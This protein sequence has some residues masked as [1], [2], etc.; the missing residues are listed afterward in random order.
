MVGLAGPT[1]TYVTNN[2]NCPSSDADLKSELDVQALVSLPYYCCCNKL[3]RMVVSTTCDTQVNLT[4]VT[5]Q[6][7][8]SWWNAVPYIRLVLVQAT[9]SFQ[10]ESPTYI[11]NED[12][13]PVIR[14]IGVSHS[15][16]R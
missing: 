12:A 1:K 15:L 6:L 9:L 4:H 7:V 5:R 3:C 14:A 11:L 2:M 8:I 16:Q 13:H 10:G